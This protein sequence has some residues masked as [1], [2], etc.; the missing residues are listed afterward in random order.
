MFITEKEVFVAE[1]QGLALLGSCAYRIENNQ[2]VVSVEQ[3]NNDRHDNNLSGTLMLQL[4]ASRAGEADQVLAQTTLGELAGQYFLPACDYILDFV[5]PAAGLWT[6]SLQLREWDG[7]DYSLRD[8]MVFDLPYLV[9]GK[10]ELVDAVSNVIEADFSPRDTD[11]APVESTIETAEV[12][13][14]AKAVVEA[15]KAPKAAEKKTAGK[16]VVA[17]K[18]DAKKSA[19]KAVEPKPVKVVNVNTATVAELA[20]IKGI[21]H[22]LAEAITADRPYKNLKELLKVRGMGARTLAK[23]ESELSL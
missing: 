3:I 20:A 18:A 7:E 15:V 12:A 22:S 1:E 9:E 17:K 5:E 8:S 6:L 19:A 13:V 14:E 16:K 11:S 2:V 21:S 4:R 10:L 23:L